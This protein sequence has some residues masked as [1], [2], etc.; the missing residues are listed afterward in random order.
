MEKEKTNRTF[1]DS[2]FTDLFYSDETAK[3]NL[4]SLYNA[5]FGTDYQ[6]VS[7]IEKV[8]LEDVLFMNMKNDIA[9]TVQNRRIVLGEHQSTPNSNMPLRNLM[10]IA[11]E[12]EKI[13]NPK[14]RY[15]KSLVKIPNPEFITF[16]NGEAE[17]PQEEILKLSDAFEI[18]EANPA[19]ELKVRVININTS[20]GHE[21]LKK[22]N[23]LREYSLFVDEVRK[24]KK[25]PQVLTETVRACINN[26][27]LADYLS[28]KG[29]EVVNM[30]MVEY[31][32][33]TDMEVQR[34]EARE[35][36]MAEGRA[37][38][39]AEG[40]SRLGKLISILLGKKCYNDAERVASDEKYREELY[41][42][43]KL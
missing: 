32:Y 6:D 18:Q 34:E 14:D 5:L 37:E 4:L 3:E 17:C 42:E 19:L 26:G 38:G 1:K 33:K 43:Y 13:V 21:I 22:C 24:H 23:I 7:I 31:D 40:E 35:K 27:I 30:L 41:R 28:R 9:F 8:R 20:H 25:S 16:Y 29:S 2:V 10:Y 12:Y 11:R 36:G 15:R 39:R